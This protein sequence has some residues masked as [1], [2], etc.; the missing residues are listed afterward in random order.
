MTPKEQI[1]F[2][3]ER[4]FAAVSEQEREYH[5]DCIA[6]LEQQVAAQP[7]NKK[8]KR[9]LWR[10]VVSWL[11]LSEHQ[12]YFPIGRPTNSEVGG[13]PD[14]PHLANAPRTP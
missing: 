2:H 5:R 10:L 3:L 9:R 4:L 6:W 14:E 12:S 1:A 8:Q 11:Q 7:T 13:P